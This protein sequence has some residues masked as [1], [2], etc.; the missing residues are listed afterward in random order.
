MIEEG[1]ACETGIAFWKDAKWYH[2]IIRNDSPFSFII[3]SIIITYIIKKVS[4]LVDLWKY[5]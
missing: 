2:G 5:I 3:V 4:I 1:S